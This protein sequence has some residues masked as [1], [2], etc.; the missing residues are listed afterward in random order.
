MEYSIEISETLSRIVDVT[1]D[2]KAEALA[3]VEKMHENEEVV[4]EPE[5][6]IEAEFKVVE[7]DNIIITKK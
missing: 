5:D 1:A 2:N 6:F 7:E 4:L 3:K